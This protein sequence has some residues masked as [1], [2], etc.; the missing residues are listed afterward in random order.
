M[1]ETETIAGGS[2]DRLS[3]AECDAA[4]KAGEAIL[5]DIRAIHEF[6]AE[7]I[8]GA[9]LVPAPELVPGALP[10]QGEKAIILQC[11]SGGRTANLA[12]QLLNAG[13]MQRVAH[14]EG[15]ILAWKAQGLP[16]ICPDPAR[17]V[18]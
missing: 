7:R 18:T 12:G 1:A 4:V 2:F 5:L 17:A 13:I 9:M 10:A 15:G 11:R 3:P 8:P 16:T 14:M 6:D